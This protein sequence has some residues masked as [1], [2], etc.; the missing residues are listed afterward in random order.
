MSVVLKS[1][2]L[3]SFKSDPSEQ[4]QW[5]DLWSY[6]P[7]VFFHFIIWL[8]RQIVIYETFWN[9]KTC[10]NCA[11]FYVGIFLAKVEDNKT[12]GFFFFFKVDSSFEHRSLDNKMGKYW[13]SCMLHFN[14]VNVL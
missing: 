4:S 8:M 1:I 7:A 3:Y 6:A 10:K 13:Q 11:P 12:E 9:Y 2:N 14:A 5:A